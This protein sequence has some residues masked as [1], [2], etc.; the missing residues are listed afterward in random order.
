MMQFDAS[1]KRKRSGYFMLAFLGITGSIIVILSLAVKL[2]GP[3]IALVI[4][5]LVL[6]GLGSL[7]YLDSAK[8]SIIVDEYSITLQQAFS[9]RSVLLDEIMGYRTNQSGRDGNLLVLV[10][11][12]N[13]RDLYVPTSLE[14]SDE[15]LSWIKNRYP[16]VD[17]ISHKE[18]AQNMLED[19]RFGDTRLKR[20]VTLSHAIL[21]SLIAKVLAILLI[22][23]DTFLVLPVNLPFMLT[24]FI[25]PWV[26]I[27]CTLYFK[28]ML[29]LYSRKADAN[30]AIGMLLWVSSAV[31]VT[32]TWM[33]FDLYYFDLHGA[34]FLIAMTAAVAAIWLFCC[35]NSVM[36]EV[37]KVSLI[38]GTFAAALAYSYGLLIYTNCYHDKSVVE[39]RRV[40]IEQK[41]IHY[42]RNS[43]NYRLEVAPWADD[44]STKTLSVRQ[45]Y[46]EKCRV[47][48]SLNVHI[49]QG[50]W[51][52]PWYK[53]DY[54]Q[55]A[56]N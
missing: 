40:E 3:H 9:S 46:Y 11:K 6:I 53:I 45:S 20:L 23:L 12:D 33:N 13:T 47:G 55:S 49:W 51:D 1:P 25:M 36:R 30:P 52:I 34:L 54:Q 4:T 29:K 27:A 43:K 14:R 17:A 39:I 15:L 38:A 2:T 18:S 32:N 7:F 42:G 10:T 48:D 8:L 22:L 50:R 24:V 26:V 44:F 19:Q 28:G 41:Y 31:I 21:T 35:R 5:G 56:E 16:D 37:R